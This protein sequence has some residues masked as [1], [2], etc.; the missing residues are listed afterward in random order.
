MIFLQPPTSMKTLAAYLSRHHQYDEEVRSL[1]SM[2]SPMAVFQALQGGRLEAEESSGRRKMEISNGSCVR[3]I[4]SPKSSITK[5]QQRKAKKNPSFGW[6]VHAPPA[7]ALFVSDEQLDLPAVGALQSMLATNN[8]LTEIKFTNIS[9]D[10]PATRAYFGQ[11]LVRGITSCHK[12]RHSCCGSNIQPLSR[13]TLS[14]CRLSDETVVN[15]AHQVVLSSSQT[16]TRCALTHLDL[17]ENPD[18]GPT[19]ILAIFQALKQQQQQQQQQQQSA[20]SSPRRLTS[21]SLRDTGLTN[22]AVA[23]IATDY[24]ADSALE[25]LSLYSMDVLL[26]ARIWQDLAAA[27]RDNHNFQLQSLS[28]AAHN[29]TVPAPD[30]LWLAVSLES[31]FTAALD[32]LRYSLRR[33]QT[34]KRQRRNNNQLTDRRWLL[35][36]T[37]ANVDKSGTGGV[38][39]DDDSKEQN[40]QL[41]LLCDWLRQ[42]PQVLVN[43]RVER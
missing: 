42:H 6:H 27:V 5:S 34:A 26:P 16:P 41:S 12:G 17:S 38:H 2:L 29:L 15:L 3:R 4:S 31:A 21:L 1:S 14:K 19:G 13:L 25:H 20:S 10:T 35:E 9:F 33:N 24:L 43:S 23:T 39:S 30:L 32:S 28:V 11:A 36:T 18:V 22:A 8:F 40:F 7:T 37:F